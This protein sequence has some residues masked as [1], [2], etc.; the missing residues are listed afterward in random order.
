MRITRGMYR[1]L[2]SPVERVVLVVGVIRE[3][4][5]ARRRGLGRGGIGAGRNFKVRRLSEVLR[6]GE[7]PD[8]ARV[9]ERPIVI[10]VMHERVVVA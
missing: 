6:L 1:R 10:V 4:S 8:G 9:D 7:V 2:P 3:S 5:A